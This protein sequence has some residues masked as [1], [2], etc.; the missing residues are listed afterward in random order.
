MSG[1]P[2]RKKSR[3]DEDPD[4]VSD[5]DLD[6]FLDDDDG[7][8]FDGEIEEYAMTESEVNAV[9]KC[10][11]YIEKYEGEFSFQ[12]LTPTD[13]MNRMTGSIKEVGD[14]TKLPENAIRSL[15]HHFHWDTITLLA[16]YFDQDSVKL[17]K[18]VGIVAPNET[19]PQTST[20]EIEDC[21]ICYLSIPTN[22]SASLE[23]GHP[24][25][26]NCLKSYL[27]QSIVD[28]GMGDRIECPAFQCK[29]FIDSSIIKHVVNNYETI[30]RYQQILINGYVEKARN[31]LFCPSPDC[32]HAILIQ[33]VECKPVKCQC[34]YRFCATCRQNWH[35]PL[36]CSIVK[37][38][39]KKCEND[40]ETSRWIAANTKNCP[41][42]KAIIEKNG[43]CNHMT[44]KNTTCRFEF[45][46]ICLGDWRNHKNAYNCNAYNAEASA[47]K[48]PSRRAL[49]R[50]LF[51]CTRYM[52]HLNSLKME[53]KLYTHVESKMADLQR[54][55]QMAFCETLFLKQ[56]V[57]VLCRCRNTLL[58]TYAFAFFLK[59]TPQA[60][61][62]EDNQKDLELATESLS[63]FFE[64]DINSEDVVGMRHKLT[65][66]TTYLSMRSD[67]VLEHVYEGYAKDW[68]IYGEDYPKK[69]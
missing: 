57:E 51:Y 10:R 23:C 14:I 6:S 31:I 58:H 69:P 50:Y 12:V 36:Q 64:K 3:L 47:E 27:T 38:W 62:F 28:Q 67:A 53:K 44:C 66:L 52:N 19:T 7:S 18:E 25:C 2:K 39:E 4:G 63:E 1:S 43:G 48:E 34:G 29:T 68:W 30:A 41:K 22:S 61:I 45:C 20:E 60:E 65:A 13:L 15:L 32:V 35:G 33:N 26:N 21:G 8:E 59:K 55:N 17:M 37:A 42:C 40:S 24:F 9:E 49:E 11:M 46:W 16:A 5:I 54:T 56:A